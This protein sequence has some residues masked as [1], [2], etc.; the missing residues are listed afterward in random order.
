MA[1]ALLNGVIVLILMLMVEFSITGNL[2]AYLFYV[3]ASVLI[4]LTFFVYQLIIDRRRS[5]Q[6]SSSTGQARHH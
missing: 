3:G 5:V 4:T 6:A 1:R 2:R